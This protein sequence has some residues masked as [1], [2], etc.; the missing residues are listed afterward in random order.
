MTKNKES[1]R[2]WMRIAAVCVATSL[3]AYAP[4]V[5]ANTDAG[6]GRSS[7]VGVHRGAGTFGDWTV[8]VEYDVEQDGFWGVW[9]LHN[10]RSQHALVIVHADGHV[11]YAWYSEDGVL[12]DA[13]ELPPALGD[14]LDRGIPRRAR[15][16]VCVSSPIAFLA[17][18]AI[19]A[20]AFGGCTFAHCRPPPSVP[21]DD[22]DGVPPPGGDG[23]GDGDGGTGG[24]D[25]G[26]EGG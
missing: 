22:G 2:G 23:H 6:G 14:L 13:G 5:E 4:C 8:T 25:T 11:D 15:P 19:V 21:P 17:C 16:P 1:F 20:V 7:V 24:G 9:E 10:E 12:V 3:A 18:A 26:G